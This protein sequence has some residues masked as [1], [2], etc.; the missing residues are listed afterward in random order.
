MEIAKK[1]NNM[2]NFFCFDDIIT[3]EKVR[4]D[5]KEYVFEFAGDRLYTI[6]KIMGKTEDMPGFWS[7][8]YTPGVIF[9]KTVGDEIYL[10]CDGFMRKNVLT[11]RGRIEE[12]DGKTELRGKFFMSSR[13][14]YLI[15]AMYGAFLISILL[16]TKDIFSIV[17]AAVFCCFCVIMIISFGILAGRKYNERIIGYLTQISK[18]MQEDAYNENNKTEC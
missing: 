14:I 11:F 3:E 16:R 15:L 13:G 4:A 2:K 17:V 7:M 18:E 10:R 12:K 8:K 6:A 5:M 1:R 9:G